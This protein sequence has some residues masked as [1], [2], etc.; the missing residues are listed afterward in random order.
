MNSRGIAWRPAF[1]ERVNFEAATAIMAVAA[2]VS[3]VVSAAGAMEQGKAAR[4][5]AQYQ[6]AVADNNALAAR[7]QSE[8]EERQYRE[9]ARL[10]LSSQRAKAAKNGV[11]A[12]E[13]SPLFVD[14]DTSETAEIDSLNIRR[15]GQLR[16]DSF[17]AQGALSLY[18]GAV[19]DQQAQFRATT[20]LLDGV[21]KVAGGWKAAPAQKVMDKNAYGPGA[22]AHGPY[23]GA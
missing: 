15:G 7:Q 20:S 1:H 11:L 2:V 4:E 23:D 6:A 17:R 22:G 5:Q 21:S 14:T 12:G 19:A 16:S 13:G 9:K 18:Q 3:A 8:L 10:A